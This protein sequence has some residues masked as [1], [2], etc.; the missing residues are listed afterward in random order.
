MKDNIRWSHPDGRPVTAASIGNW[1]RWWICGWMW[2]ECACV[3]FS[4]DYCLICGGE[5]RI[6]TER[7]SP[8]LAFAKETV[9]HLRRGNV[10]YA[11]AIIGLSITFAV[12]LSFPASA[13]AQSCVTQSQVTLTGNLRSAN[14]LPSSNYTMTLTPSQQGFIAGCGV[15]LPTDV[16]CGTSTDGSVIG[17]PNPLTATINTTS[18]TGSLPPSTYYTIYE[19][20]D[21]SGHATLPSP[22]TRTVLSATGSLVVNPP[23]SGMPA[24]AVGM[25]VFIATTSGGETLQ[26]ST[27]GSA[28]YVQSTA[29]AS[30]ASPASSNSTLCQVTANDSVWPT[31]TGYKVSL[32]DTNGNAIPGYP[33]QWQLMGAGSTINLSNGLPYYH[34][35]VQYPVPVLTQ[36]QNHGVQSITGPLNQQGYNH[37]NL[38]KLGV[39]TSTPGYPIDVTNGLINSDAGYLIN[40]LAGT[41]GQAP[42]S[43]GTAI[44]QFCTFLTSVTLYYQTLAIN[45]SSLA[46]EPK[47]NF[48][49][50]FAGTDNAGVATNIDLSN[51][52]VTPGSYSNPNFTV[53]AKGRVT[54]ASNGPVSQ[55]LAS[56]TFTSC[57]LAATV[58]S[59]WSCSGG[60]VSWGTTLPSSYKVA[61][62]VGRGGYLLTDVSSTSLYIDSKTTTGFTYG[63]VG[64]HSGAN[65]FAP[66]IDCIATN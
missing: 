55:V 47:L 17:T 9:F 45:S 64:D 24:T 52:T 40:G 25:Y 48:S 7:G 23:S 54:S 65:G 33:M 18:G 28:S 26:G 41:S 4:Q 38:G 51:T 34:G 59:T 39:G 57:S 29:L 58:G 49:T 56:V 6:R 11:R 44:D 53:D 3:R 35:V 16:T 30:G 31:G 5:K 32:V 10:K 1:L 66:P 37:V 15:N 50:N 36:P 62:S 22:E 8:V 20:Y 42:C 61:C 12:I 2:A 14:G 27:T 21:A 19:F 46:Q 63:L 13:H 43:D 60:P